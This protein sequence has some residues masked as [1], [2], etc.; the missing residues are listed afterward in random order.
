LS[1]AVIV[2]VAHIVYLAIMAP[3][4]AVNALDLANLPAGSQIFLG[5]PNQ[6]K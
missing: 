6:P 3:Y 2:A 1:I 5:I 4:A